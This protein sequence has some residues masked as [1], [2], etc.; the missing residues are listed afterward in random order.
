METTILP[1]NGNLSSF[2]HP[3]IVPNQ[4]NWLS[5]RE[6]Q[7]RNFEECCCRSFPSNYGN[8]LQ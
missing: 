4:Y 1:N 3:H 5:S 7:S 8:T 2:T 6:N